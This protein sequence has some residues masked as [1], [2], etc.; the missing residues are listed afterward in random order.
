M[1][2][3]L[4]IPVG[5]SLKSMRKMTNFTAKIQIQDFATS[6]KNDENVCYFFIWSGFM[7]FGLDSEGA[8]VCISHK[9]ISTSM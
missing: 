2:I 5:N 6:Q 3:I 4:E 1:I 7:V 8:K 9:C